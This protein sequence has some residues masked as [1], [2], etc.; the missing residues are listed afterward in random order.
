MVSQFCVSFEPYP[1]LDIPLDSS[2]VSL[3]PDV[4]GISE[5][6]G[7]RRDSTKVCL[8]PVPAADKPITRTSR[9]DVSTA[10]ILM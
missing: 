8:A 3:F 9:V 4:E 1:Q 2:L 6:V 7:P 10:A 5:N